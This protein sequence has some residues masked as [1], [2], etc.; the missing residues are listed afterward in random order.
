MNTALTTVTY[1]SSSNEDLSIF[2]NLFSHWVSSA[3]FLFSIG[4][5]AIV[6]FVLGRKAKTYGMNPIV[7][8]CLCFFLHVIGIA[9]SVVL[10]EQRKKEIANFNRGATNPFYA[11]QPQNPF[12]QK[13]GN[14]YGQGQNYQQYGGYGYGQPQYGQS[15]NTQY[16]ASCPACG[17]PITE[18]NFC[19]VCGTRVR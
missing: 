1:F 15:Y 16:T 18:G 4:I 12:D 14:G 5:W 7:H 6:G 10:I 8:F 17:H 3:S 2:Y 9:I 11:Q 19:D 13:Y